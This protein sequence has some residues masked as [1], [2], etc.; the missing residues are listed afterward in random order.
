[1]C[2]ER[3][4]IYKIEAKKKDVIAIPTRLQ[5]CNVCF[6]K[7]KQNDMSE[8]YPGCQFKIDSQ[9]T[10]FINIDGLVLTKINVDMLTVIITSAILGPFI[11]IASYI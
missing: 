10:T 4:Q 9:S 11:V 3:L 6:V 5:T 1:M 2:V 7:K 8:K